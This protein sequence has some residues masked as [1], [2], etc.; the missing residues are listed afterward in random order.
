[1]YRKRLGKT[2]LKIST[3]GF[4]LYQLCDVHHRTGAPRPPAEQAIN[5]IRRVVD[6]GINFLDTANVYCIDD[7]ELGYGERLVRQALAERRLDEDMVVATK[8]IGKRPNGAWEIDGRPEHIRASCERSLKD[9]GVD[10]ITLYQLHDTD[11]QVPLLETVGELFRL[12]DEG[13]IRHIGLSN[14]T[15]TDIESVLAEGRIETVQ[16]CLN[17]FFKRHLNNGVVELCQHEQLTFI[18]YSPLGGQTGQHAFKNSSMLMQVAYK[19]NVSVYQIAIAW[20]LA[21]GEHIV[22]IPA[23]TRTSTWEDTRRAIELRLDAEDLQAIGQI[24]DLDHPFAT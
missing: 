18:P 6:D 11:S 14:V 1:M 19:Y 15:A 20:L 5:L 7:S 2:D 8:G 9:L 10:T 16:N 12:K 21:L 17:P 23:A 22:P 13:K 4:G 24:A 3:L